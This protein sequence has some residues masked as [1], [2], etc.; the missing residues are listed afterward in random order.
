MNPFK[1]VRNPVTFCFLLLCS[2]LV[3]HSETTQAKS[4]KRPN[5]LL[6]IADDLNTAIGAMGSKQARTPNLDRLAARGTLMTRAFSSWPSCLPSR[7]SF[8]SGW[9]PTRAP[10]LNW[11][12]HGSRKG[13]YADACY[14]PQWFKQQGYES[15]RL[16]KVFHIGH[17][18]P[19]CWTISEEPR[20]RDNDGNL[21]TVWTGIEIETL[22]LEDRVVESGR[23]PLTLPKQSEIGIFSKLNVTDEELFD[24]RSTNR[25][26]ELLQGARKKEK[27]FFLAVGLR[28]PHL[29]WIA[30]LRY[31]EMHPPDHVE[32]PPR[33]AIN[34]Q[35]PV[36]EAAHREAIS[37]Y[38]AAAS[39]MDAQVGKILDAL[40][41]SGQAENTIVVLFG[42]HGYC[43]GERGAVFGKGNLWD[44]SLHT[45]QL[46]AGPGI[47]AGRHNPTP[48]SLLDL[49]PTLVEM[50]GL[51][52][53]L[54]KLD[55][56]SLARLLSTGDDPSIRNYAVSFNFLP[57]DT[58]LS[59]SVR[60]PRFRYTEDSKLKPLELI[61]IEEDPYERR[62]LVDHSDYAGVRDKLAAILKQERKPG[63]VSPK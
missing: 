63:A 60:T 32:L 31:F 43:L 36:D 5:V 51:D 58:G 38:H 20:L 52:K 29:P 49:Y 57:W 46:F 45:S 48:I 47:L 11:D 10:I 40:D 35:A 59:A 37:H 39:Y 61:D 34:G 56:Q 8:L 15:Y 18:D 19:L 30:P 54:T 26:I 55:G 22:G 12:E 42:D 50:C 24:G 9:Q 14:L 44:R 41:Q 13:T 2:A 28:R 16:D 7:A 53:P 62:N 33:A 27:P 25:A 1:S 17:D 21:K 3:A 6:I 4:A 23:L